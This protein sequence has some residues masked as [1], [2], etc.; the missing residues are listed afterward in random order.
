MGQLHGG[1]QVRYRERPDAPPRRDH[2]FWR[3]VGCLIQIRGVDDEN[4]YFVARWMAMI[5]LS[6]I[7]APSR[8]GCFDPKPRKMG[9]QHNDCTPRDAMMER[10]EPSV[11]PDLARAEL[12]RILASADFDAS[13]RNHNF[14]SHVIEETL[15]GRGKRIKAYTIATTVF[16]RDADFDPHLDS[17]VRIEAG[18]LRRSLERYYLKAGLEN[19]LRI[20]LPRGSYVPAFEVIAGL[21][22]PPMVSDEAKRRPPERT[23]L[24]AAFEEDGG[25][26]PSPN[27]TRGFTRQVTVALTRFTDLFV[28][29]ADALEANAG[30]P[31]PT[32]R[33]T[34]LGVDFLLTGGVS[35]TS[36][37]FTVEVT[38]LDARTRRYLWAEHFHR[39][40]RPLR[41]PEP[42]RRGGQQHRPHPG[43]A[44]RHHL[45]QQ[46]AGGR[47]P[48]AG[49][50][51][52]LRPCP[53]LL[54]ILPHLRYGRL[55]KRPEWP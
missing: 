16:G 35:V 8:H 43:A 32:Q 18:R 12:G 5:R 2:E 34:E 9:Q 17:I 54:P 6:V 55:R 21:G 30:D 50:H 11:A 39:K 44:L 26:S 19:P 28:L 25:P 20:T 31:I 15:A 46:G 10:E 1:M 7:G 53:P 22:A 40:L 23:I 41:N 49:V 48:P 13:E 14:L 4:S 27:F 51:D 29:G 47:W 38:L 36:E 24:V 42:A 52:L 37:D 45:Q 3:L 33:L